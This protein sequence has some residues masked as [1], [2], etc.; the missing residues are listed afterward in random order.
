V[1]GSSKLVKEK[2]MGRMRSNQIVIF[3]DSRDLLGKFAVVEINEVTSLSLYGKVLSVSEQEQ[4][5]SYSR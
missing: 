3:E 1:E 5:S 2:W 4:C